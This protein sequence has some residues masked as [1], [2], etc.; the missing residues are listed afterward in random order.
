M[1]I[2]FCLDATPIR[3]SVLHKIYIN[4]KN[5]ILNYYKNFS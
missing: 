4:Y 5:S 3:F 2:L 1:S